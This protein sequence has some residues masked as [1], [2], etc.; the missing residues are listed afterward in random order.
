MSGDEVRAGRRGGRFLCASASSSSPPLPP[1]QFVPCGGRPA[2]V[3]ADNVDLF[4]YGSAPDGSAVPAAAPD[5]E[6]GGSGAARA[7]RF[8]YIVE[9]ANLFF[10]NDARLAIEKK[11]RQ[12]RGGKK[13]DFQSAMCALHAPALSPLLRLYSPRASSSSATALRTKA[14]SRAR[15]SRCAAPPRPARLPLSS[16]PPP[17]IPSSPC[18]PRLPLSSPPPPPPS[19]SRRSSRRS[20]S[21]TPSSRRTCE[22]GCTWQGRGG[23]VPVPTCPAL[24]PA[25]AGVSR[26]RR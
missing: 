26:S 23:P 16:P 8:K 9:G 13:V 12:R 15:P 2:A 14:A 24:P 20:P 10:T 21:P 5:A 1:P 17:V 4:L 19:S 3:N 22:G 11:V 18:H 7:P 6:G 25:C